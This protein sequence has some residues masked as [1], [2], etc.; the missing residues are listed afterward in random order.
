MLW[1]RLPPLWAC[2]PIFCLSISLFLSVYNMV[3]VW[4]VFARSTN[5]HLREKCKHGVDVVSCA[6]ADPLT[7]R[8][9]LQG[10]VR[11]PPGFLPSNTALQFTNLEGGGRRV[12]QCFYQCAWPCWHV[13][14][15][16]SFWDPI[17]SNSDHIQLHKIWT[18]FSYKR[19]VIG[20][21]PPSL[22]MQMLNKCH[23][24]F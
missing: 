4:L 23:F 22:H 24:H 9:P 10:H 2:G 3:C 7:L 16:H 19:L 11:T 1:L 20:F 13:S 5:K 21:N 18:C 6:P 8:S 17:A 14:L 12:C 15:A